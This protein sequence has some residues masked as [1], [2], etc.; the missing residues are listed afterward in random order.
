MSVVDVDFD[1]AC[2]GAA[3]WNEQTASFATHVGSGSRKVAGLSE[4]DIE[5]T[6]AVSCRCLAMVFSLPRNNEE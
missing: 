6:E 4:S 3:G 5:K 2:V 1:I